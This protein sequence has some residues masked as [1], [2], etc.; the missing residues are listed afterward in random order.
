MLYV[1]LVIVFYN[2]FRYLLLSTYIIVIYI[3]V[4]MY[5]TAR[6]TWWMG[7]RLQCKV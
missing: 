5:L 7:N 3:S 1:T 4:I 6:L 2:T